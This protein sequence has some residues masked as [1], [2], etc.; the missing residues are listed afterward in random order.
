[1][2]FSQPRAE[3]HLCQSRHTC[4]HCQKLIIDPKNS[5]KPFRY[6]AGELLQA[7][8]DAC[9]LFEGLA[10]IIDVDLLR[11]A[12]NANRSI[13]VYLELKSKGLV[14]SRTAPN[15]IRVKIDYLWVDTNE[16]FI[17]Y[18]AIEDWDTKMETIEQ[19]T[20]V[21]DAEPGEHRSTSKSCI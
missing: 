6:T 14:K 7:S 20:Y 8:Q 3:E 15:V 2:S 9:P 4:T 12:S 1:M 5:S 11:I 19:N 13:D 17:D 16:S 18:E 10:K 21:V